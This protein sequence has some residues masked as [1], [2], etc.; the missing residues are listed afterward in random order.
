M[1][2]IVV[3]SI[4]F[5]WMEAL[6]SIG[7]KGHG[8]RGLHDWRSSAYVPMKSIISPEVMTF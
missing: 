1:Y 3:L 5:D 6:Q 8:L 2:I 7:R 4:D